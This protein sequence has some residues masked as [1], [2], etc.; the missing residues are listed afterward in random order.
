MLE[1]ILQPPEDPV[2]TQMP[3]IQPQVIPQ[4]PVAPDWDKS[5]LLKKTFFLI[6]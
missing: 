5:F 3:Q 6:I 2:P 1:D 4:A